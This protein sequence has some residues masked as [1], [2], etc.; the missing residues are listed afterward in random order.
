MS[1]DLPLTAW[2]K[3]QAALLYY[4]SS[5]KYLEGLRDRVNQIK[6]FAEGKINQS[7][8]EGRDRFLHSNQWGDRDTTEN[9]SNN[10]WHFLADFQQSIAEDIS[11]H[12]SNS[13]HVTGTHQCARGLSEYSMQWATIEEEKQFDAMFAELSNYARNIDTT[14]QKSYQVSWWSDFGLTMAWAEHASELQMIP[15]FQA[16]PEIISDT[17]QIPPRTGVYIAIDDPN[18][19]LQF[20][21]NGSRGGKIIPSSTFNDL[22]LAALA[23]VG[24]SKLWVDQAAMRDFVW[25][26]LSNPDLASDEFANSTLDLALAPSV[27]ARYAFMARPTRWCFVEIVEGE[28]ERVEE[29][30]SS[31]LNSKMTTQ[32]FFAGE[33]CQNAGYYF[34]PAYLDSRRWFAHGET[35]PDTQSSYGK[36]IWQWDT[37]QD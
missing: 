24:R 23:A 1:H 36:S 33:K 3:K 8:L 16:R 30:E 37:R 17:D 27:V 21:W 13:F 6:S 20:A 25:A 4:F 35:F 22:G 2:Q 29:I 28:F 32:R 31:T 10:A 18:A 19:S 26:N 15:K 11:D 7:R 12:S 34:T 14:M 5:L 9:W